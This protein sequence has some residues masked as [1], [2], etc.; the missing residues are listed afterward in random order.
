[1]MKSH[2][3]I[4]LAVLALAAAAPVMTT[5]E[6]FAQPAS[7]DSA[8]KHKVVVYTEGQRSNAV[9]DDILGTL[10]TTADVQTSEDF[11]KALAKQGQKIPF[12]LVITLPNKR[13]PVVTRIGK[14]LT[15]MG[16]ESAVIGF[17]RPK[18]GGGREVLMLVVEAGKTDVSIDQAVALDK[19]S[20][21]GDIE[22][23]LKD[24]TEA[25]KPVEVPVEKKDDEDGR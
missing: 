13:G 12:G 17:V 7:K 6:A 18:R 16:A 19:P 8:A 23:A 3:K 14:A 11:R 4:A 22:A 20:S 25:W 21:K 10:P 1:M 9:K 5:R 15:A 2:L 24:M